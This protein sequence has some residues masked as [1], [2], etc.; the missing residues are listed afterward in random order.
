MP[1]FE[2]G[3][4]PYHGPVRRGSRALT[5]AWES[6]RPRMR[7]WVWLVA[8]LFL[9]WPYLI[10]GA[11][12]YVT[13]MLQASI[14]AAAT[15]TST[16][17]F[18]TGGPMNPPSF[19]GRVLGNSPGV[20][21]ELLN[22]GFAA[23]GPVVLAAVACGGILASDRQTSA[24]Q[25]YL[26]RPVRRLDYL[27]GKVL[28]VAGFCALL[29]AVPTLLIWLECAALQQS[30]EFLRKTWY[31]PF[32]IVLASVVYTVWVAGLV[33]VLSSLIKRPVLVGTVAIFVNLFLLTL[34][35]LLAETLD[36]PRW[37]VIVPHY[38]LGAVTAP[39]FGL[40]VPAWL[41]GPLCAVHALLLPVLCFAVVV[42]RLRA[43]EVVT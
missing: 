20:F 17:A 2:Q 4:R 29:T 16:I 19:V 25:I 39:L 31:V 26:S 3:Y 38:A 40:D 33:L 14:P 42:R 30:A 37:K 1:I 22:D 18:A 23:T 27:A 5:I 24:L 9:W 15:A 34:G 43:V 6:F 21:W 11:F 10:I 8:F 13:L 32:S 41:P 28:A 36:E 12:T 35:S 7:W